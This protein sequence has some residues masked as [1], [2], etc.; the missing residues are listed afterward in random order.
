MDS[1]TFKAKFGDDVRRFT[2]AKDS[3]T[4]NDLVQKVASTFSTAVGVLKYED[5]EGDLVTL[6]CG[7]ELAEAI[8]G[9]KNDLI[10]LV[11]L[12]AA[13]ASIPAQSTSQ[14]PQPTQAPQQG[15]HL[16]SDAEFA[17][18]LPPVVLSI[19]QNEDALRALDSIS[20]SGPLYTALAGLLAKGL[21]ASPQIGAALNSPSFLEIDLP[22]ILSDVLPRIPHIAAAFARDDVHTV[23]TSYAPQFAALLYS[24]L[25]ANESLWLA[26]QYELEQGQFPPFSMFTLLP[27]AQ[28]ILPALGGFGGQQGQQAQQGQA[29]PLAGLASLFGG[30]GGPQPN[31]LAGLAGLFGSQQQSQQSDANPLAGLAGLAS[32]FGGAGGFGAPVR[33]DAP[34]SL[35][36]LFSAFQSGAAQHQ[37]ATQS[38][39]VQTAAASQSTASDDVENLED[40]LQQLEAMGFYDRTLNVDLLRQNAGNMSQVVQILLGQ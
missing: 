18:T 10:R 28:Y 8:R 1:I 39:A 14:A 35:E 11:V 27:L 36:S 17:S 13:T 38:P 2:F 12:G 20:V 7:E 25:G 26:A 33:Q 3:L 40:K 4:F 16:P 21:S 19:L 30:A 31:P 32:L 22:R 37:P 5:D 29:N 34:P 6:S 9:C 24:F 23:L 15:R